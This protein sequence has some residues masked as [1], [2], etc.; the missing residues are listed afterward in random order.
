[1]TQLDPAYTYKRGVIQVG[2]EK[3]E[4]LILLVGNPNV[5]KSVIF[6]YLTG[7]YTT[8]SNYPGTTV[9]LRTG[10]LKGG[11]GDFLIMD[12]P[13]LY[14]LRPISEEERVTRRILLEETLYCVVHV[15]EALR[16][17]RMLRFTLELLETGLPLILVIN[18]MDEAEREGISIRRDLLEREL[19]IPVVETVSIR[20][21]GMEQL[22]S[23]LLDR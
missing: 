16:L 20:G 8:V 12:T 4:Q 15:V 21:I 5:G 7:T 6:H 11:E 3:K 1:M 22:R 2:P 13:G 18:M 23:A 14:S 19:E 10:T 9:E 17:K